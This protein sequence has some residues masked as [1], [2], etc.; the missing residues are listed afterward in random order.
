MKIVLTLLMVQSGQNLSMIQTI[1]KGQNSTKDVG[2]VMV[3]VLCTLPDNVLY[4]H[5]VPEKYPL[6][7]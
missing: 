2:G 3:L 7:L 5:R 4:L 6:R 1:S